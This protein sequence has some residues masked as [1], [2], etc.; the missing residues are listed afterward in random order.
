MT[1]F[2][3]S[4]ALGLSPGRTGAVGGAAAGSGLEVVVLSPHPSPMTD[5]KESPRTRRI[6]RANRM[7]FSWIRG[8]LPVHQSAHVRLFKPY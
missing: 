6:I 1:L 7:K 4:A 2:I 8:R 5:I 3:F